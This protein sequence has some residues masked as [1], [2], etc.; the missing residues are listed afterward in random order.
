MVKTVKI[1][2]ATWQKLENLRQDM[3]VRKTHEK[4][5]TDAKGRIDVSYEDVILQREKDIEQVSEEINGLTHQLLDLGIR[6]YWTKQ[7]WAKGCICGAYSIDSKPVKHSSLCPLSKEEAD[8][9]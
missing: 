2:D 7:E 4:M 1:S 3:L 9:K 6:P 8:Q 5:I